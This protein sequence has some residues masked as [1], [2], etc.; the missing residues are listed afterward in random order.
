MVP[1]MFDGTFKAVSGVDVALSQ[2]GG[3]E[4]FT[5]ADEL[6]DFT[7]SLA[8]QQDHLGRQTHDILSGDDLRRTVPGIGS[9]VVGAVARR[10]T[11]GSGR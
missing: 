11:S 10:R 4:F 5:D 8:R 7:A 3:Y 6:G 9:G 2:T 1:L